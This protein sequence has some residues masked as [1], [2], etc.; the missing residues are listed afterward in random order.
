MPYL[1]SRCSVIAHILLEQTEPITISRLAQTLQISERTV[2]YDLDELDAWLAAQNVLLVRKRRIG[3]FLDRTSQGFPSLQEAFTGASDSSRIYSGAERRWHIVHRLLSGLPQ[4]LSGL[5]EATG[6]SKSTVCRDLEDVEQWLTAR[7]I[8]LSRARDLFCTGNE[9]DIRKAMVDLAYERFGRMPLVKLLQT[10]QRPLKDVLWFPEGFSLSTAELISTVRRLQRDLQVSFTDESSLEILL[11][12]GVTLSRI[13]SG[14]YVF[15]PEANLVHLAS[16]REFLVTG[17]VL[18]ELASSLNLDFPE[19]ERCYATMHVLGCSVTHADAS[20]KTSRA[21]QYLQAAV[22]DFIAEVS[23]ILGKNLS[24]DPVLLQDLMLELRP[25][26]S[27]A[28]FRVGTPHDTGG[29]IQTAYADIFRAVWASMPLLEVQ[30]GVQFDLALAEELSAYIAAAWERTEQDSADKYVTAIVVC[31]A[32]IGA[33]KLLSSRITKLFPQIQVLQ[34]ISLAEFESFDTGSVDIVFTAAPIEHAAS[35][36]LCVEPLL[37]PES[38]EQVSRYLRDNLHQF[39][40][41]DRYIQKI[42]MIVENNCTI[43]NR[44]KLYQELEQFLYAQKVHSILQTA[45]HYSLGSLITKK[46][47]ILHADA[48]DFRQAI[49]L[50]GELLVR[51]GAIEPDYIR[52]MIEHTVA[53]PSDVVVAPHVALAHATSCGNVHEVCMSLVLLDH[54]VPF[55]H[56]RND[57][58]KLVLCLG[59]VDNYSHEKAIYD[60]LKIL[61]NKYLLDSI[62]QAEHVN[63]ILLTINGIN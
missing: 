31:G 11:Y 63:Q 20:G 53:Y 10:A 8:Y 61:E 44:S 34:E 60:L 41:R 17:Q 7:R 1:T 19:A 13:F 35:N 45:R 58:V 36:V 54:P 25:W 49:T 16:T 43:E 46:R 57:P 50:G 33:A 14:K 40:N 30:F 59:T 23:H 24:Q 62:L 52:A 5:A 3:V 26:I 47:I 42:L 6:V 18:G 39:E 29:L 22:K 21:E 37:G 15:L 28:R 55:H 9:L 4:N 12:F 2:R 38:Q 48:A 51:D 56:L 32:G 27:R